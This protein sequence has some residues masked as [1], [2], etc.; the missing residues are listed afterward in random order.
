MIPGTTPAALPYLRNDLNLRLLGSSGKRRVQIYDPLSHR[1]FDLGSDSTK[2]LSHWHLRDPALV[3]QAA[4]KAGVTGTQNALEG[5]AKFL[6]QN[7]LIQ[8]DAGGD[9]A[10]FNRTAQQKSTLR[11]RF[12][13]FLMVRFPFGNPDHILDWL[14]PMFVPF[15]TLSFRWLTALAAVMALMFL[16]RQPET[17]LQHA[18]SAMNIQGALG[19]LATLAFVKLFHELGH[20]MQAKRFG[21]KVPSCGIMFM[22]GMPLPFVELSNSWQLDKNSARIR[23]DAG[24]ILAEVTLAIW[25]ALLFVFWPDGAGRQIL[26]SIATSS[27]VLSLFV[28]LNPLM[29][30]DGYF[31]LSDISGI[32]NLQTRS[33]ALALW[34]LRKGLLGLDEPLPEMFPRKQRRWMIFYAVAVWVY[35]ITLY[36]GIAILAY[37]MLSKVLGIVVF[38]LEIWVFIFAPVA[39]ELFHWGANINNLFKSPKAWTSI[40]VLCALIAWVLWP[41]PREITA[42]ARL[43][44]V[45]TQTVFAPGRAWLKSGLNHAQPV[46]LGS[47]LWDFENPNLSFQLKDLAAQLNILELHI[48]RT[49]VHAETQEQLPIL[50]KERDRLNEDIKGLETQIADLTIRAKFT[51][52]I[53]GLSTLVIKRGGSK[54]PIDSAEAI[55]ILIPEDVSYPCRIT[56]LVP[57]GE[58]DDLTQTSNGWFE[59]AARADLRLPVQLLQI[60]PTPVVFLRSPE[61]SNALGGPIAIRSGTLQPQSSWHSMTLQTE[62]STCLSPTPHILTGTVHLQGK[63]IST[64]NR[65]FERVAQVLVKEFEF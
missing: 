4:T 17:L 50:L 43:E 32:R 40:F 35:R 60:S 28:N 6:T 26:F 54:I 1:Y 34:G 53:V 49:G 13:A 12:S 19:L 58:R 55:G 63:P 25:A 51:G 15:M 59:S 37:Q 3:V 20:A 23:I 38:F 33:S 22:L 21:L 10:L 8:V 61:M 7:G 16:I 9:W 57:A 42:P 31:L 30:F 29:R 64:F 45:G 2:L 5:L 46:E 56:A 24:G 36:I 44:P 47:V 11:S 18:A 41:L 52:Q 27:L 48:V 39:K 65:I 62:V 14:Y